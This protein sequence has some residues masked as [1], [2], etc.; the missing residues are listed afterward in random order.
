MSNRILHVSRIWAIALVTLTLTTP[1]TASAQFGGLVK[2][3][4]KKAAGEAA[5]DAATDKA[6]SKIAPAT[7]ASANAALGGE[8]TADTLDMLL[9]GLAATS[10]KLEE[11]EALSK[12]RDDLNAKLQDNRTANYAVVERYD[13]QES[14]IGA[15]ISDYLEGV[16]KNRE[17]ELRA[18]MMT[19]MS[20][21]NG[22]QGYVGEYQKLMQEMA[23][24]QGRGDTAAVN[25]AMA[26]FY[27][28]L[29]GVDV[30]ADSV[31]AQKPCGTLP[32]KPAAIAEQAALESQLDGANSRIRGAEARASTAGEEASGLPSERFVQARERLT[33]WL[34]ADKAGKANAYF[35]DRENRLLA[36]RKSDIQRVERALR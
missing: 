21:P 6:R 12:Q 28:K 1:A 23:A 5:V 22:Q 36:S 27:K 14:K 20:T 16:N 35:S 24:A 18:K 10:A 30:H 4:V 15:C 11:V 8:L 3:A 2:K 32:K 34:N 19:M 13:E 31:A 26:T 7:N 17:N 25:K 33:T 9:K 29:L